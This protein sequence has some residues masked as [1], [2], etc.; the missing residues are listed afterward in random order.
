MSKCEHDNYNDYFETCGD[1]GMSRLEIE[2]LEEKE[3]DGDKFYYVYSWLEDKKSSKYVSLFNAL[4]REDVLSVIV[5]NGTWWTEKN[6]SQDGLSDAQHNTLAGI[7]QKQ[8]NKV[9]LYSI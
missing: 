7:M 1:C 2:E 9:W 6:S 8:F 4:D 3:K 5:Y